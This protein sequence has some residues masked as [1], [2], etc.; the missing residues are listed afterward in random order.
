MNKRAVYLYYYSMIVYLFGSIPFI[1]YAILMKPI[2]GLYHEKPYTIISPVFGNMGIYMEGLLVIAL[3]FIAVSIT[4]Y[5]VSLIY[6]RGK[7]GQISNRTVITPLILYAFTFIALGA[8][9]I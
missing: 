8:T 5:L 1:L 7:N 4:L 3:A 6:N 9:L 2:N